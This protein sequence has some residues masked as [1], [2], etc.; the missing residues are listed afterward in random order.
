[1]RLTAILVCI[2]VLVGTGL[3]SG[4]PHLPYKIDTH[5]HILPQVYRAGSFPG[6]SIEKTYC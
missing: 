4:Q 3:A 1:M 6:I 2:P 5:H